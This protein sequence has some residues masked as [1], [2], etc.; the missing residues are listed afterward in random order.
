MAV[1]YSLASAPA[2]PWAVARTAAD[3][4]EERTVAS[5]AFPEDVVHSSWVAARP[6][7]AVVAA[8]FGTGSFE[9]LETV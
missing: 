2:C 7:V 5:V 1:A 3:P 4:F 9:V 6:A 8:S